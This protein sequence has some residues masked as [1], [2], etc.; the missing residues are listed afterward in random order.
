MDHETRIRRRGGGTRLAQVSL[1]WTFARGAFGVAGLRREEGRREG[2]KGGREGG[3][4]RL[5]AGRAGGL[6]LGNFSIVDNTK[7]QTQHMQ[8]LFFAILVLPSLPS[9]YF[10][11]MVRVTIIIKIS[12]RYSFVTSS[13]GAAAAVIASTRSSR[14]HLS[15]QLVNPF[16]LQCQKF[17]EG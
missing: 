7:K 9:V 3:R 15:V 4:G 6:L 10:L 5:V 13:T 12:Y 1:V 8:P 2:R 11:C 17:R 16:L 14:H